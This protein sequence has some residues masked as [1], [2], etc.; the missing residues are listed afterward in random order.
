MSDY[1]TEIEWINKKISEG[2]FGFDVCEFDKLYSEEEVKELKKIIQYHFDG[3]DKE[4]SS[5][6]LRLTG[7][8]SLPLKNGRYS[9]ES[10]LQWFKETLTK[11]VNADSSRNAPEP[12]RRYIHSLDLDGMCKKDNKLLDLDRPIQYSY[13]FVKLAYYYLHESIFTFE[14]TKEWL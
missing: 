10:F 2:Y 14:Q 13:E 3:M 6:I 9:M 5:E 1:I 4:A 8:G 12:I 7:S 11:R